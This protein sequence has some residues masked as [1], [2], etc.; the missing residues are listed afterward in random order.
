M[1]FAIVENDW[2]ALCKKQ[3]V[4]TNSWGIPSFI[5]WTTT[6]WTLPSNVALCVGPKIEYLVVETYNPY[7]ANKATVVLAST[8]LSAYFKPEGEVKEG[9]M[10]AYNPTDKVLPYRVVGKV[11]GT[12]LEDVHYEQLMKWVKPVERIG[13]LAPAF[14]NN[15]AEVH[16]DK[17]FQSEDGRD[18]F[19]EM[20]SEAFRII[21][22][23]YVTTEDG[24][25]IVHI[26]PTFGADDAKVAKDAN[27]PALYLISKKGETRPMVD[28]QGKY[29][30]IEELDKNFVSACVNI[31]AYGKH[32]GDYVKN[33]Y[34]PRFNPD[35]VWDKKGSEKAED[36]N[37]VLC[38]EMKM[39]GEAFN[40]QKHTHNYPHC[41]RTDKPILYYPLDSWFIKR[42]GC[43]STNGGT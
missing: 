7:T 9:E 31:D 38:M 42:Y 36:L 11:M 17:V 34:D 28:L 15:Y 12:D 33:A 16:K 1:Q 10:P 35:G 19:V 3:G 37:I 25:G 29:Y 43:K 41:W 27:I 13:E 32:A 23:D 24:T 39:A 4:K 30:T 18:T 14:V 6:P 26:A 21:L 5:A 2:N 8:R 22:G 20:E 40:I